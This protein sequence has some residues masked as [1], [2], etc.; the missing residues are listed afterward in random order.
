[1]NEKVDVDNI[2]EVSHT[3]H[4]KRGKKDGEGSD[5]EEEE[6][7]TG[8]PKDEQE[9]KYHE[10]VINDVYGDISSSDEDE[11]DEEAQEKKILEE[12]KKKELEIKRQNSKKAGSVLPERVMETVHN[13]YE[14]AKTKYHEQPQLVKVERA[15]SGVFSNAFTKVLYIFIDSLVQ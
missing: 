11:E 5:E 14:Q 3:R 13:M 1:M 12:S 2:I 10:S 9:Q 15:V 4:T 8:S 7:N 6:A